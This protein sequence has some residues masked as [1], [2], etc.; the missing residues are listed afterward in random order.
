[1]CALPVGSASAHAAKPRPTICGQHHVSSIAR[2]VGI[3]V[4]SRKI[5]PDPDDSYGVVEYETAY[6]LPPFRRTISLGRSMRRPT[7]HVASG[8]LAYLSYWSNL[9]CSKYSMTPDCWTDTIR[10]IDFRAGRLRY[11][12]D[13]DGT[14]AI[15][16]L[17]LSDWGDVAW[18]EGDV[19]KRQ[20]AVPT[21][22][23]LLR[24]RRGE[25]TPT[26]LDSGQFSPSLLQFDL[27]NDLTWW[28]LDGPHTA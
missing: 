26:L 17:R 6:C 5:L 7:A 22:Q 2:G 20:G 13:T 25:T 23:R 27:N 9:A 16:A 24:L 11:T 10:V 8:V 1:M 19:F 4:I 15:L 14:A 3:K 28:R 21:N 12:Q 18:I